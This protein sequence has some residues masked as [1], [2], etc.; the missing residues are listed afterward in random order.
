MNHKTVKFTWTTEGLNQFKVPSAY[1]GELKEK[2]GEMTETN[3]MVQ[4]VDD[5]KIVYSKQQV[6]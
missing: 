3:N 6:E 2:E 1:K 4:T 5:N